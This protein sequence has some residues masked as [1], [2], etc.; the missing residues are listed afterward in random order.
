MQVVA[1][2]DR[3]AII[4]GGASFIVAALAFVLVFGYL[5][6]NFNYPDI[7]DGSA[8]RC[9]RD[10]AAADRPCGECGPSTH[11]FRCCLCPVLSVPGPHAHR[12][13]RG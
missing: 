3:Q 8:P 10:F 12:V 4:L 1:S 11:S 7:L 9:C 2:A 5:A 6:A 13:A